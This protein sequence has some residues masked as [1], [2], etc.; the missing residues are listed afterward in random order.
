MILSITTKV[1]ITIKLSLKTMNSFIFSESQKENKSDKKR[2]FDK[3]L[4]IEVETFLY[5]EMKEFSDG[6]NSR[7][8]MFL[9]FFQDVDGLGIS[10]RER[11]KLKLDDY[12]FCYGEIEYIS[13]VEVK[14]AT[15]C[16]SISILIDLQLF[17]DD[18]FLLFTIYF[19]LLTTISWRL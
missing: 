1:K 19:L 12:N 17:F 11:S 3:E 5:D 2:N 6:E 13:F 7:Y 9:D 18:F 14:K 8:K 15:R 4:N 16:H 10:L